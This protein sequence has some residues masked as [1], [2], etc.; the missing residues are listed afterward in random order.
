[1]NFCDFK[2]MDIDGQS[3]VVC[4]KGIYISE[5]QENDCLVAL[6]QVGA[7]YVEVYY[8]L[9]TAQVIK[10]VSFYSTNFLQPYLEKLNIDHLFNEVGLA[11]S[12]F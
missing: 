10:L 7:F 2:E 5:R 9:K 11:V 8:R 3:L 6:Y 4:Q 1:M 12:K